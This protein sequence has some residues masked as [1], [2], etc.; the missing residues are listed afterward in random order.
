MSESQ[1]RCEDFSP[2]VI[3]RKASCPFNWQPVF[4]PR[5]SSGTAFLSPPKM[6]QPLSSQSQ[7]SLHFFYYTKEKKICQ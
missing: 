2:K 6:R 1:W 3:K 5:L 4:W 7:I